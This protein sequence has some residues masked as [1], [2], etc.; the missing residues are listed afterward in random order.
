MM[1]A[2]Y[3]RRRNRNN[4]S[5]RLDGASKTNQN[6]A[7][8]RLAP[9]SVDHRVLSDLGR[10][11]QMATG[12]VTHHPWTVLA[13]DD[14]VLGDE[15]ESP[16]RT[17]TETD[18]VLFTGL[19]GDFNPLHC[20]HVLSEK[21]PFGRPVAH[22]LL[23]LAVASGLTSHAPRV[24]TLAFLAILEWRFL[25]PI[26]FGDTIKVVSR[27]D[28]LEPQ[29]RGRRGIVTWHRQLLNQHD[30]VVQEG[31]TQTLVRGGPRSKPGKIDAANTSP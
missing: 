2:T 23:G 28:A 12:R 20:N 24:D 29:A 14:L 30:H 17:V 5:H 18:V 7:K 19:S 16:A 26:C 13:F 1:T 15:W 25:L 27:I 22:G 21:G 31:R 8:L 9:R 6:P 11:L 10:S 3:F 4:Q